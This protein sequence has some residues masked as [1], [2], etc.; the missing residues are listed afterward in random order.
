M[1]KEFSCGDSVLLEFGKKGVAKIIPLK[2]GSKIE[3]I[4]GKHIGEEGKI[5]AKK[6]E[7][8]KEIFEIKLEEGKIVA[9][10]KKFL[11]AI[12]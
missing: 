3:V 12:E 7:G 2:E 10:D 5:V 4:R 9:L 1:N 6:K 11:L 8:D